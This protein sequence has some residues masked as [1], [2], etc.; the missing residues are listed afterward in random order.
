MS[1][2]VDKHRPSSLNKLDYHKD[3]ATLLKKLVSI[4]WLNSLHYLE[5]PQ[6]SLFFSEYSIKAYK[7]TLKINLLL[8]IKFV[9]A[10]KPELYYILFIK[11]EKNTK[12]Y[13]PITWHKAIMLTLYM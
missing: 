13:V 11:E 4:Y 7:E 12:K 2:W 9:I 3:Q 1:L 6:I 8:S 10:A 5:F